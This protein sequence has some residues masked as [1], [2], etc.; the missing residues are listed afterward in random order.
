MTETMTVQG[1]P[2]P[3]TAFQPAL[4]FILSGKPFSAADVIWRV[5]AAGI[6]FRTA[7]IA[8]ARYLSRL[9]RHGRVVAAGKLW[10]AA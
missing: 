9:V 1:F 5:S 10:R 3:E 2:V 8:A 4:Q 7:E 6:P